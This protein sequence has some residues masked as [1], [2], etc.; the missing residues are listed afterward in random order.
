[1]G[2]LIYAG[3]F[4]FIAVGIF[5][6]YCA[7]KD[8]QFRYSPWFVPAGLGCLGTAAFLGIFNLLTIAR[9]APPSFSAVP[10]LLIA[11]LPLVLVAIAYAVFAARCGASLIYRIRSSFL[12]EGAEVVRKEFC[13]AERAERGK[14]FQKAAAIYREEIKKDSKDIEA[15]RRLAEVL[16]RASQPRDAARELEE[17]ISLCRDPEAASAM[18]L[19]LA[20]VAEQ[21]LSDTKQAEEILR[22]LL[23]RYPGSY[24]A[25][26]ASERL[27]KLPKEPS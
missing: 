18:M 27:S 23:D 9:N 25:K 3:L 21:E 17:A 26:F 19:R 22:N 8:N 1:M 24:F 6:S 2:C 20:G 14:D 15:R 11:M 13:A 10:V 4:V 5:F 12:S 16:L 7:L